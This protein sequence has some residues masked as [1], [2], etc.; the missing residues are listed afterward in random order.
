MSEIL[1]MIHPDALLD[2]NHTEPYIQMFIAVL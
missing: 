1:G 2:F